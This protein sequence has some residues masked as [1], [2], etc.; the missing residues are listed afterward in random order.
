MSETE[1]KA[2]IEFQ[3]RIKHSPTTISTTMLHYLWLGKINSLD[4]IFRGKL[5]SVHFWANPIV[6]IF[7]NVPSESFFA[8]LFLFTIVKLH[9]Q[10]KLK[11]FI[12]FK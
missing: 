7:P 4:A 1:K 12:R 3:N 10:M 11:W 8:L 6:I 2:V 5:P 9:T